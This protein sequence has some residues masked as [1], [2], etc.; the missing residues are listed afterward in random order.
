M[1]IFTCANA[2]SIWSQFLT[3]RAEF[4]C[5]C[6]GQKCVLFYWKENSCLLAIKLSNSWKT[7]LFIPHWWTSFVDT[8]PLTLWGVLRG[9]IEHR[10]ENLSDFLCNRTI[11]FTN[12]KTIENC[13]IWYKLTN[14]RSN[15][16]I[17]WDK[18][19]YSRSINANSILHRRQ[20]FATDLSTT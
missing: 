15:K 1:L 19:H 4:F 11:R 10:Q 6:L 16:N 18:M 2:F 13:S 5:S 17:I 9:T 7:T 8:A 12:L 3:S 14:I 20:I